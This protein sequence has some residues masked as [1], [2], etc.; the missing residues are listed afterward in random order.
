[1]SS[2][3]FTR[4]MNFLQREAV[5]LWGSGVGAGAADLTGVVSAG[6][7]I[8]SV[9]RTGTGLYTINLGEKYNSLLGFDFAVLDPTAT[10]AWAVTP[11]VV[12]VAGAKTI[13]ITVFKAG[14]AADLTS[15][16]TLYL[17]ISLSNTQ[18]G[19]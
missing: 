14:V 6:K 4:E 2:R 8:V 7:G 11:M 12:D 9:V 17:E 1:M 10:A 19:V 15:D 3:N 5:T 18:R 13:T 16:E